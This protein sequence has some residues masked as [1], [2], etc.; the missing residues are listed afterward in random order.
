MIFENI[1]PKRALFYFEEISKIPHGSGNTKAISDYCA[2]F[3][4]KKGLRFIQD[5]KGNVI[6]FK[7]AAEGYENSAPVILQGH[8]DMVCEKEEQL[9]FD[10]KSDPLKLIIKDG[11]L[12]AEGTTLGADDGAAVSFMLALLEDENLKAPSLECVFTVD[13]EIGMLGAA[14][15]DMS[16]LSGRRMINLDHGCEDSFIAG[17]AG[18][19]VA[20]CHIP[21]ARDKIS[22][23]MVNLNILGAAGGHSGEEI[24]KQRANTNVLMGRFLHLISG[25]LDYRLCSVCGGLK[26]NAI[27]R[28]TSASIIISSSYAQRLLSLSEAFCSMI[29]SEYAVSD[30]DLSVTAEISEEVCC[31]EAMDKES[32]GRVAKVICSLPAGVQ[33]MSYYLPSLVQT[34]LNMGILATDDNE[35]R[36]SYCVRSSVGSEKEEVCKRLE[37]TLALAGGF[38]DYEGDYPAWEYVKS[39]KLALLMTDVYSEMRGRQPIIETIHAGLECGIFSNNLKGLECVSIGPSM[40]EIH[41]TRERLDLESTKRTWDFLCRILERMK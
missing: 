17:C 35:V 14:A 9:E 20:I 32:T 36:C 23:V 24:D 34:S 31:Y 39:S 12:T 19:V 1:E 7:N 2:E 28:R 15:M 5:E 21:V 22:G 18:G 26:D 30:P 40:D 3:A 4:S 33:K 11:F 6:I 38:V 8:M 16:P 37:A 10:F 29:K 27:P 25:E 13:E 41:T